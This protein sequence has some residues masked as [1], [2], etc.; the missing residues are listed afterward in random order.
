MLSSFFTIFVSVGVSKVYALKTGISGIGYFG[1]AQS[2]ML[3]LSLIIGLGIQS[4][5][6]RF[7]APLIA[8][9][10]ELG[11]LILRKNLEK[12]PL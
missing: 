3:F 2:I 11:F 7:G 8:N 6:I 12:V 9:H 1:Y 4:S 10:D 5:I